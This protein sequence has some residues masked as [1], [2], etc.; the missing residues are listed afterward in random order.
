L[1][2]AVVE[3]GRL[4]PLDPLPSEWREGQAVSLEV[5]A[6]VDRGLEEL[7][8]WAQELAQLGPALYEPGEREQV[9]RTMALA[10]LS[11]KVQVRSEMGIP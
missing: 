5:S 9:E 11:A 1:I 2:R 8:V 4:R 3:E 10:D 7:D 6:P